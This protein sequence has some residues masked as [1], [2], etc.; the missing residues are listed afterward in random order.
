M[1]E[2]R[3]ALDELLGTVPANWGFQGHQDAFNRQNEYNTYFTRK[4]EAPV[5]TVR[6]YPEG[7]DSA[8][9]RIEG[10]HYFFETG[11]TWNTQYEAMAAADEILDGLNVDNRWTHHEDIKRK[12]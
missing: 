1:P 3:H 6:I 2:H 11:Q 10:P 4:H 5:W 9:W 8:P 12:R 7:Q